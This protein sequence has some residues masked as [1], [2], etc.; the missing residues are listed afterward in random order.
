MLYI[1][2]G[3]I[4]EFSADLVHGKCPKNG[5]KLKKM[6]K[7]AKISPFKA[8]KTSK[9]NFFQKNSSKASRYY[10]GEDPDRFSAIIHN[11]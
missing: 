11:L 4:L 7:N 10:I 8:H 3:G 6:L 5:Q 9:K 1:L 2:A